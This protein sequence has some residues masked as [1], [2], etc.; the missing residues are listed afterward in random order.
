ML[1]QR[2]AYGRI[3]KLEARDDGL[4]A[5]VKFGEEGEK[6]IADEAFHGHSTNWFVREESSRKGVWRPFELASVGFTNQPNIPVEPVTSA[7]E[8]MAVR[9]KKLS[10]FRLFFN[11]SPRR[12][13]QSSNAKS[14]YLNPDGTFKDGFKGCVAHMQTEE[15]GAH[16]EASATKICGSI[17]AQSGN[18]RQMRPSANER[19]KKMAN[20]RYRNLKNSFGPWKDWDACMAHMT[21]KGNY[22]QEAAQKVCGRLKADLETK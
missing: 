9:F 15:G 11:A 14:D 13:T 20:V 2:K 17:A 1:L 12:Q 21:T 5:N 7:N 4:W 8:K 19:A 22:D 6:L 10:K 3:K 18:E 16:S